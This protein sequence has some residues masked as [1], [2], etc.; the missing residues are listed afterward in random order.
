MSGALVIGDG[1]DDA[2]ADAAAAE[3]GIRSDLRKSAGVAD[4]IGADDPEPGA[5]EHPAQIG[6]PV[7]ELVVAESS[8]VV[9]EIV[10]QLDDGLAGGG[11]LVDESVAGPPV[12]GVDEQ[13]ELRGVAASLD[14]G[15]QLRKA[16]DAGVDVV[17]GEDD[18]RTF[19]RGAGRGEKDGGEEKGTE[20]MFHK[21]GFNGRYGIGMPKITK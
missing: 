15:G 9:A 2:D 1:A 8:G 5:V 13:H 17:G 20:E 10:H 4:A 21:N 14:G 18:E 7:V 3:D 6:L 19:A 12:A 16:L 11:N